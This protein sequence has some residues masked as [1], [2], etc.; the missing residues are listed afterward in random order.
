MILYFSGFF[1]SPTL[2]EKLEGNYGVLLSYLEVRGKRPIP[3]LEKKIFL[4][5]GA[6]SVMTGKATVDL[7]AYC[8][9]LLNN[10]YKVTVYANLDVI[11]DAYQT[12]KNQIYME[13][14]GLDPLPTFHNGSDYKHL[15]ELLEKYDYIGLGGL[16]PIARRKDVLFKHL[17]RC[18]SI[19]MKENPNIRIHGWGMTGRDVVFRYPF[20]SVDSTSWLMG[21]KFRQR[22]IYNYRGLRSKK[23]ELAVVMEYHDLNIA[24][25]KALYKMICEATSL[26]T[27]RGITWTD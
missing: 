9:F 24:N 3:S 2:V 14:L 15:Y 5:S 19:I 23:D 1:T 26:W 27:K 18:F 20:Y 13:S 12:N 22:G 16:V 7:D 10:K 4:D 17:D 25:A 6:F 8:S 11:G 21:G